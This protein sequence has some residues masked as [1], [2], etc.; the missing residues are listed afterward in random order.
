MPLGRIYVHA[1]FDLPYGDQALCMSK[2]QFEIVGAYPE[3]TPNGEDLL[4]IRLAKTHHIQ[5]TEIPSF[6]I[7]SA[8]KYKTKG[9][10]KT[11]LVTLED[12][13]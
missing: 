13:G 9:W 3:D 11:T 6:L 12:Y 2:Q 10:I 4:F 8:R 1:W 5:I 7:S